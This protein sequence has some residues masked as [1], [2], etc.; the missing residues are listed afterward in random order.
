MKK[1]EER[2]KGKSSV[3]QVKNERTLSGK[4]KRDRTWG[5]LTSGKITVKDPFR[6][7]FVRSFMLF[8]VPPLIDHSHLSFT[9]LLL[10]TV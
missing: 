7:S 8:Q 5:R 9:M 10:V 1:E 3:P 6:L 4:K 2:T